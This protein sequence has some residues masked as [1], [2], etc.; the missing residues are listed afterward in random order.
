M[1]KYCISFTL[2][3]III[4]I[5]CSGVGEGESNCTQYLRLHIRANSNAQVDQNVKYEIKEIVVESLTPLVANCQSKSV[6]M[7]R[8]NNEL[9]AINRLIDGFLVKK[10]FNY[11]SKVSLTK[12]VFPTREY[13]GVTLPFGLYDAL[14]IE[15]GSGVGDNWWCVVYPPLCF[16]DSKNVKYRSLI[17]DVID[18]F[19]KNKGENNE[20]T[21]TNL[22]CAFSC[23][24]P[25]LL[26]RAG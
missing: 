10:G 22:L 17:Y 2:I 23:Y 14:I 24:K 5:I 26:R 11:K 3:L 25:D 21:S 6:A 15:L 1:K 16:T 8:L 13:D 20:K 12:E 19:F 9:T 18:K 4:L 7:E